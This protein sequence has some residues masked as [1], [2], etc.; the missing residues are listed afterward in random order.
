MYLLIGSSGYV[1]SY[2]RHWF[3][4]RQIPFKTLS[5]LDCNV[6]DPSQVMDAIRANGA[7]FLVNCA[8]Y[9]GNPNVDACELHKGECLQSNAVLP[10]ILNEACHRTGICWGHVSSG[11][12]YT[13]SK[14]NG[15]GFTE[16]CPPNFSFRTNNSSFYSGSKALG[17]EVVANSRCCYV[18]RL[19]IP[20]NHVDGTRNYLSKLMR[21]SMLLDVANS[22]CCIDDFVNACIDCVQRKLPQG[23]YN[24]TNT[25]SITTREVTELLRPLVGD[26]KTFSFFASEYDFM[27]CAAKTPRS[28]CVLDNSKALSFGL[29]L[30]NVAASIRRCVE[31]WH[32]ETSFPTSKIYD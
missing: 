20:F 13:G 15:D 9:T 27:K 2:F 28:S 29:K 26:Q 21:Y 17:E 25:G 12:I 31:C 6:F 16:T 7:E 8:G 30:P 18:W 22:L 14:P 23:T 32:S 19:R 11:C 1:G 10:A 3:G 4:Q 24:M 5:R